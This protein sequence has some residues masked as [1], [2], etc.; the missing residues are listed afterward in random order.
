M[1]Y[2][3]SD[4]LF[5]FSDDKWSNLMQ[6]DTALGFFKIRDAISSTK[7]VDFIGVFDKKILSIIEV[8]NFKGHR[9]E[10]KPRTDNGEDP[11]EIEVAK[12]VRD[13]IAGII[14]ANRNATNN[15]DDWKNYVKFLSNKAKR[16]E[17]ILWLEEDRDSRPLEIQKK[18]SA[19]KGGALNQRLKNNLRWLT[20]YVQV[21]NINTPYE[22]IKANYV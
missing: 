7:A 15:T 9:I 2:T 5:D 17:V 12:K 14:G 11:L 16:V 21:V 1:Q 4:I 8:K 3:E 18:R 10:N 20:P 13:S 22:G 6:Y 19:A